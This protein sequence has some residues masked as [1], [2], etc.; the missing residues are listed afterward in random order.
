MGD[1]LLIVPTDSDGFMNLS[2]IRNAP[3]IKELPSMSL[4][5]LQNMAIDS[6][7]K[8]PGE[9]WSKCCPPTGNKLD[10]I[11]HIKRNVQH[12]SYGQSLQEFAASMGGHAIM[13]N[14]ETDYLINDE[15][16]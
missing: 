1:D 9:G 3:S 15:N 7:I 14:G 6:G 5:K 16:D 4:S 13:I 11:K 8:R 10:I 12:P 2:D